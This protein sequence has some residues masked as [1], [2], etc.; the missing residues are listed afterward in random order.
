MLVTFIATLLTPLYLWLFVAQMLCCCM[1]QPLETCTVMQC[2]DFIV[3]CSYRAARF[4]NAL[5]VWHGAAGCCHCMGRS[6]GHQPDA[7]D[8]L[9]LPAPTLLLLHSR[10]CTD[11]LPHALPFV[12]IPG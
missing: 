2:A 6:A 8:Q 1:R 5:Q 11:T 12:T 7:H 3:H 10:H 4:A 9:L